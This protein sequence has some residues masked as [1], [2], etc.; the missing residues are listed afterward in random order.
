MRWWIAVWLGLITALSLL[1]LRIKVAIG[2]VGS[3]HNAGHLLTFAAT[4]ALVLA[5]A[6]RA[7][8]RARRAI[9]L[10]VFCS[11]L[12]MLEAWLYHNRFEWGDLAIDSTGICLGW[13]A[14]LLFDFFSRLK[15]QPERRGAQ[16]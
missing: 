12:E 8:Q 9:L 7:T 2:T 3:W 10:V 15:R 1:P 13:I 5:T 14:A 4:A 16:P 6:S 11:A